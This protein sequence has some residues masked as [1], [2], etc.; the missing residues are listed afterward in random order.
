MRELGT[1]SLMEHKRILELLKS[2][3]LDACLVG[4]EFA[5][6]L[7]DTGMEGFT[8]FPDSASLKAALHD[9]GL[10]GYAI[11]VKGSRGIRMEEVLPEL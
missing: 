6:A 3:E 11:L 4:E 9:K 5:K 1:E 10:S 8:W 7:K 2:L